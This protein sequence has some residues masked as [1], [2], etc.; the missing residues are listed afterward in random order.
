[1]PIKAWGVPTLLEADDPESA[2]ALCRHL[3]FDFVELNMNLPVYQQWNIPLL[4]SVADRYHI[5]FTIHLDENLDLCGF[6]PRIADAY[7][8]TLLETISFARRLHIPVL[9]MHLS[10]GVHFTLPGKKVYLYEM[11]REHFLGRLTKAIAQCE[12]AAE[13][14]VSICLENTGN[15][16]KPF[17]QEA[18]ELFL[19]SPLF[20]LTFDIGHNHSARDVDRPFFLA[21]KDKLRHFHIHD[22]IGG[23]NH[24]PLGTGEID[25]PGHLALAAEGDCRAVL[26]VKTAQALAGSAEWLRREGFLER[27]LLE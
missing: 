23:K 19:Q 27:K 10:E 1:M 11:Y 2:A 12:E 24:L 22:A 5:F 18:L 21:H 25:L 6:N 20:G 8:D 17:L 3:G 16:N 4:E 15:F 9:N 14:A 13:G 26:E 7:L